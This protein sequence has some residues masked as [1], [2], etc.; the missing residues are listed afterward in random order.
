MT[1]LF[2]IDSESKY[3]LQ[4]TEI[5]N[6]EDAGD[7]FLTEEE[8]HEMLGT[9]GHISTYA[10]II[11]RQLVID[12]LSAFKAEMK[13]NN[14]KSMIIDNAE[15]VT[16]LTESTYS[17]SDFVKG[18]RRVGNRLSLHTKAEK[19]E[20]TKKD[21]QAL[22][23][24]GCRCI[25]KKYGYEFDIRYAYQNYLGAV[26]VIQKVVTFDELT[27]FI[28]TSHS[29]WTNQLRWFKSIWENP[30]QFKEES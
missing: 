2:T 26:E 20:P 11:R 10:P 23:N 17:V 13:T 15:L 8:I 28:E 3:H 1:R 9:D 22:I 6:I 29:D 7:D 16:F 25:S 19:T 30:E 18:L 21:L 5:T 14:K 27:T 4:L 24:C 12:E